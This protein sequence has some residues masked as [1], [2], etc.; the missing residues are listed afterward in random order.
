MIS[1]FFL[2]L[3]MSLDLPWFNLLIFGRNIHQCCWMKQLWRKFLFWQV[4][5]KLKKVVERWD[6]WLVEFL[7]GERNQEL[8]DIASGLLTVPLKVW[9]TIEM[10][11]IKVRVKVDNTM[12]NISYDATLV[13]G[14]IGF[15]LHEGIFSYLIKLNIF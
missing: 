10:I 7:N 2:I 1:V 6:G 5:T 15:S 11:N 9:L 13:A 4:C 14:Q 8:R 12:F 3:Q